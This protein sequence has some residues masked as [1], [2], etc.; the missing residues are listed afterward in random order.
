MSWLTS[1]VSGIFGVI[2]EPVKEWQRR[3]TLKVEQ[4]DK[5][6][7]RVH[8]LN[9]K[10]IDVAL[11][12]AKQ[13]QKIEADWDTNAQQD[14]KTSWKDEYLT[15]LF[16]IPLILAFLP[17]TQEAVLKGFETLDKTPQWYMMLV[18]GIVAGVFGLRWLVSRKRG[19]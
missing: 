16:S 17:S 10:K 12:L 18:T 1:V 14:M 13:G 19:R 11:E 8:E 3:E 6:L 7:E 4:H 9:I 5:E 15:I 2:T